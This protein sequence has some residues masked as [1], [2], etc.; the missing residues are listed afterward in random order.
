MRMKSYGVRQSVFEQGD[1]G[2]AFFIIFSGRVSVYV[3]VVSEITGNVNLKHVAELQ[4]GDSF[5]ELALIYGAKR[6]A[7]I[8][9]SESTDLIVLDKP[10]YDREIKGLQVD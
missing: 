4:K 8:I 2:D 10:V 6:A 9:T 7:S 3:K 1:E 5:G